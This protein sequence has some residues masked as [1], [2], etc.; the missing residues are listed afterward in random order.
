MLRAGGG[1][2][3][4]CPAPMASNTG[5]NS[6]RSMN[7]LNGCC[8]LRAVCGIESSTVVSSM[9]FFTWSTS[10]V[11]AVDTIS[12]PISQAITS[13][14]SALANVPPTAS[15]T[16]AGSQVTW[17]RTTAPIVEEANWPIVAAR[18]TI[19]MASSAC[20]VSPSTTAL[21]MGGAMKTPSTAPPTK[22]TKLM[23]PMMKPC[24]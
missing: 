24:R 11:N 4:S 9:E 12:E 22:P 17:L 8:Q 14:D 6:D 15:A 23:A 20:G 13:T 1:T 2:S 16:L 19:T 18:N 7:F 10:G 21:E 3:T 5:G